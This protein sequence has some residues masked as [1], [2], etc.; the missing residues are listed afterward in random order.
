[1][2]NSFYKVIIVGAG[3]AGI[4]TAIN[5]K[6]RGVSDVLVVE[7]HKFPRYKCCA[8]YVTDKTKQE[9][10]RAGL[11][12]DGC[13]Y[14]LIKDFNIIYKG[15]PRL[16]IDNKFLY[17]NDHIDRV[18]L[19]YAFFA[20][21]VKKNIKI[22]QNSAICGHEPQKREIVLT[23]GIRV[24]YEYIV[25]AD[26]A[27]GF[28]SKYQKHK[29]KNIAMQMTFESGREDCIEIHFG[30]TKRGYAWVSSYGGI[31]NVGLTDV[32]KEKRDYKK[33]FSEFLISQGFDGDTDNLKAA[34]TP[35]GLGSPVIG[36]TYFVGDAAGACDPFTLSGLRYALQT[37]E[38]CAAAISSGNKKIYKKYVNKLKRSFNFMKFVQ[39]VFYLKPVL[40]LV[41]GFLCRCFG[42]FVSSVFNNCFVNKK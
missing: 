5:L 36:N 38:S 39:S 7:K 6:K 26:G 24:G 23:G 16:K 31:T 41:F 11:D 30:V 35:I 25:F 4:S 28:G 40:A 12:I 42:K 13:N 21:A 1:M 22:L 2:I 14:S 33:I 9:F 10:K 29:K 32:F 34:F 20:L 3:P 27:S 18:K 15:K 19:D 17:T 37:G 8:G